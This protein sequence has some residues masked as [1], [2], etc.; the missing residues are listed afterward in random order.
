MIIIFLDAFPRRA[1]SCLGQQTH[2]HNR[3]INFGR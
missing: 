1:S 3:F 2:Q